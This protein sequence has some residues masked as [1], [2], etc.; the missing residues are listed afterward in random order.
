MDEYDQKRIK[1]SFDNEEGMLDKI[2]FRLIHNFAKFTTAISEDIKQEI[3]VNNPQIAIKR[4]QDTWER[5]NLKKNKR[6]ILDGSIEE[7]S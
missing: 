7:L 6:K 2:D 5:E 1:D 4:E 3:E